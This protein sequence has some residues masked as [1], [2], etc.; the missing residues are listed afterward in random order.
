MRVTGK[1]E[2]QLGG[3]DGQGFVLWTP[4]TTV[5]GGVERRECRRIKGSA[6]A[7]IGHSG[8]CL[9]LYPKKLNLEALSTRKLI[10]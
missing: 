2:D 5:G 1:R 9:K 7:P 6:R 10:G 4:R 3:A 8:V